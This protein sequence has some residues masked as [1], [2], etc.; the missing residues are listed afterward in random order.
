[1]TLND[2]NVLP[3]KDVR[4]E[5]LRCCGSP[6]WAKLMVARRPFAAIEEVFTTAD[7]IW[8]RLS[9]KDWKEA[10]SRHPKIGDIKRLRKRFTS[11]AQWAEGEQAGVTQTSEKVLKELAEGNR[12]YEAKFGYIFIVCATGKSA[13]EMLTLLQQRL[14]NVPADELKIAAAEQ[15]KITKLRLVKVLSE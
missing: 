14:N 11:T 4:N 13:G 1:M 12:L 15:A 3:E 5:L 7:E 9:P 10:F 2:L 6:R 8:N